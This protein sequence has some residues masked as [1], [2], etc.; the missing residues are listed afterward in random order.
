MI[1]TTRAEKYFGFRAK[2][3][4]KEG[5]KQTIAWYLQRDKG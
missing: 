5:L 2:T 1:D 4:L 3:F